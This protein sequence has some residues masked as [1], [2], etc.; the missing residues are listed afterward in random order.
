MTG[1]KKTIVIL[2]LIGCHFASR[3]Q[4]L[5][6]GIVIQEVRCQG[7]EEHHYALYLPSYFYEADEE[8][9][10]VIYTFDA[11]ARGLVP[12]ELFTEAA[13]R[14]G[15]I[16]AG[17]N[18]SENGPWE[19]ILK[20]AENMMNDVESRFAVDRARRY[21]AGF[22]GGARVAS[23]LAV[24]Y[25]TFEG[26][27]GCGAGFSPNYPPHFDLEFSYIGLVGDRDLH[28]LEMVS[29]DE[30]L[31]KFRIDHYLYPYPGN[32]EWPPAEVLTDAVL[33]LEFKAMKNDLIWIDYGL[34]EDFYEHNLKTIEE[35]SALGLKYDAYL[36]CNKLLSY[37]KGIRNLDEI[38]EWRNE[39]G[40]SSEVR[41]E[42]ENLRRI[43]EEE[44]NYYR[45]YQDAFMGYRWNYEDGMTPIKP[46]SWWK[47]QL[48]LAND[49]IENGKTSAESLLGHRMT[50]FIWRTAY[51]QYENVQGTEHQII[52]KYY[53]DIWVL[54]Q[55][56]AIS[57]YFFL[58]KYYTQ[59]GKYKKAFE[60]LQSAVNHGLNERWIIDSDPVLVNLTTMPEF[61]RIARQL[62]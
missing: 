24:L 2:L 47:D 20:A 48:K 4:L 37:L 45:Q 17:S 18:I 5:P 6:A 57:P 8:S 15:Y 21:T 28:Y 19:P 50:D 29:L 42:A 35:L 13:E 1:L 53:L 54:A 27:I 62:E 23:A 12:V 3:A 25:G 7:A 52:S 33:W 51:M 55:P 22:S 11:A 46:V 58:S 31:D 10:P 30:W 44:R 36:L 60:A 39:L 40:K 26:V 49:K 56:D 38:I 32:H 16:I 14:Y 61:Q 34:R 43:F 41:N 59:Q 9:W